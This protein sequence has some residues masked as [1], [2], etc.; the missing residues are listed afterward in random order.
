MADN[1]N[2]TVQEYVKQCD[3][4]YQER[5]Q[6]ILSIVRELVPEAQEKISWGIPLFLYHGY[7]VQVA[8]CKGYIGFYPGNDAIQAFA[9]ELVGYVCTKTAVHLPMKEALPLDLIRRMLLFCKE[10]NETH[11]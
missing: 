5:L 10:Y 2:H 1:T 4:A 11:D 3:I 8:Q 9:K 7:L 6:V